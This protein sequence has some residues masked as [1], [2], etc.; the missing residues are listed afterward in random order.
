MRILVKILNCKQPCNGD[1]NDDTNGDAPPMIKSHSKPSTRIQPPPPPPPPPPSRRSLRSSS[2]LPVMKKTN[3]HLIPSLAPH[4]P[5]LALPRPPLA[6]PNYLHRPPT[7]SPPPRHLLL[8]PLQCPTSSRHLY[9]RSAPRTPKEH[10]YPS[11]LSSCFLRTQ[12]P[13]R[14]GHRLERPCQ[15][16]VGR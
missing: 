7:K 10:Q 2:A 12:T 9:Q 4:K 8:Y 5:R 16:H 6:S 15:T 14:T 3:P 1:D 11:Q 13:T